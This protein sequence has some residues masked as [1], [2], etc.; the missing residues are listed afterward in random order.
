MFISFFF[1][2]Q[3]SIHRPHQGSSDI[4]GWRLIQDEHL[5]LAKV[6]KAR[7]FP[8]GDFRGATLGHGSSYT[9]QSILEGWR[10]LEQ[11]LVWII[12]NGQRVKI[13]EDPW[14]YGGGN[15]TISLGVHPFLHNNT[16]AAL[17]DP[18]NGG[19]DM[20]S[21]RE[22]F[23]EDWIARIIAILPPRTA[24]ADSLAWRF[25][26]DGVYSVRSGYHDALTG[27]G[28]GYVDGD[29]WRRV[30]GLNVIPKI[31]VFIWR[32]LHDIL[33]MSINL[34]CRFVDVDTLCSRCGVEVESAEHA[35]RDCSW[36]HAYWSSTSFGPLL[37]NEQLHAWVK[38]SLFSLDD[39]RQ[40][41][42]ATTMWLIW[43]E[44]NNWLFRK[45]FC[46]ADDLGY[47]VSDHRH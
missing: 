20:D 32:V 25:T 26:K 7:Y 24:Y 4:Q 2:L 15:P 13:F 30:W 27:L 28:A 41:L 10:V 44:R 5:L 37:T 33:P 6:L 22:L 23:T 14:L 19:W 45:L 31:R 40:C 16:V 1:K 43:S 21:L 47:K 17:I 39:E 35:L 34:T 9:W 12:G 11:G 36:V 46:S 29:V 38:R 42:L 18:V 8:R 3:G